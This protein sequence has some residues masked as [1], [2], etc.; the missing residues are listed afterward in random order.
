MLHIFTLSTLK[1][2]HKT[3]MLMIH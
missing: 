3:V 2:G 1:D